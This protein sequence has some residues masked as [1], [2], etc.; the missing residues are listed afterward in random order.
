MRI[1]RLLLYAS[2]LLSNVLAAQGSFVYIDQISMEGN[3]RT[4][5]DVVLRELRFHKGDSLP[6]SL[7]SQALEES[8][9][10]IMNTGLFQRANI[11]F[12]NWEGSTNKVHIHIVVEETWY[13]YPVPI[14]ELV[15][16]NF[17]VWWV[18]QQRSLD[19]INFGIEFTH[20]NFTGRRDKL[21]LTAK[22]GY[23]RSYS[24]K[25]NL[26]AIN[27]AKTIG[28][29]TEVSFARNREVNYATVGNKQEFYKDRDRFLYQ[30][31]GSGLGVTYRPGHHLFHR[32]YLAYRQNAIDNLIAEEFNPN[33]FLDGRNLSRYFAMEYRFIYDRRDVRPYP[34]KGSFLEINLKKDGLGFFSDRNA[35]TLWADFAR[36]FTL[37]PR[38]HF[39]I[40]PKFKLSLIRNQQPYIDYRAIGFGRNNIHG[41]EYYIVDG[42]DMAILKTTIRYRL[43]N[44]ELN[45]GKLVPIKAFRRMPIRV[46]L[47]L[48]NDTGIA[49]DPYY[50]DDNPLNR[51][52]LWGGG[53]GI[54]FIF[55]YDKVLRVEFSMNHLGEKGLFLHFNTNI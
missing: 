53:P 27:R 46:F 10:L 48:N 36:Y 55:Y 20:L 14:V 6:I 45:F 32:L 39:S 19:R 47:T 34:L 35:L 31:F 21:K 26:P 40:S 15:D 33:F 50:G 28:I 11:S 13:I 8:E 12:K 23:T 25:Y 44:M 3:R 43:F 49:S 37:S 51:Q 54:D 41:F 7:L 9:Q 17:N 42:L 38:F 5:E 18:E 52:L 30:R 2:L 29:D 22:Y 24:V 16:R 4:K 1:G